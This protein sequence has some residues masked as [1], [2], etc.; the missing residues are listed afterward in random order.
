MPEMDGYEAIIQ[1]R[2]FNRRVPIIAQT[3]FVMAE[4]R[5]LAFQAGC[6]DFIS[7]PLKKDELLEK[8]QLNC[9][10]VELNDKPVT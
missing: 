5:A 9:G 10:D 6:N 8:I 3:A 4:E 2:K 7:K 1:I